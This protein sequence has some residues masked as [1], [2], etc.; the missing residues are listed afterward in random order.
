MKGAL[1]V[2]H[3]SRASETESV[4]EAVAAMAARKLG[5]MEIE[6]AFMEFSGRTIEAGIEA[7]VSRGVTEVIIAPYFLFMGIHMKEDIP[8]M[9]AECAARRPDVKV[10]MGAPLNADERLADILADRIGDAL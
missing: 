5:G 2:A 10:T 4:V 6:C 1:V 8:R 9:A 7:L 3:G